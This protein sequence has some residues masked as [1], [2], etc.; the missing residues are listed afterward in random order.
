S[1]QQPR[2]AESL[3]SP[4]RHSLGVPQRPTIYFGTPHDCFL[5]APVSLDV[6]RCQ[7]SLENQRQPPRDNLSA[8]D[9][10]STRFPPVFYLHQTSFHSRIAPPASL[11]NL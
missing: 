4:S 2:H 8:R 5:H 7:G 1:G 9:R 6:P 10:F 3:R 11:E